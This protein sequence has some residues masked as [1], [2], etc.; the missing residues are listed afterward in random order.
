MHGQLIHIQSAWYGAEHQ[1]HQRKD[2]SHVVRNHAGPHVTKVDFAITNQ[3]MGG[4]PA[5]GTPKI[6]QVTYTTAYGGEQY[7]VRAGEG[8]NLF[9][10][11]RCQYS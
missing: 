1:H 7:T 11:V 6:A 8:Q 10:E 3:S 9:I 5:P 2:I 4:D